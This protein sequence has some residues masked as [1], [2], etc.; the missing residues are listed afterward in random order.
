MITHLQETWKIQ[1][2]VTYSSLDITI[3]F[4]K[5][6]SCFR[7][8]QLLKDTEPIAQSFNQSPQIQT[9]FKALYFQLNSCSISLL[10]LPH[11]KIFKS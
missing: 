6:N 2:K 9:N 7:T 10:R 3:I 8:G 4:I 11:D 5:Q 1:N